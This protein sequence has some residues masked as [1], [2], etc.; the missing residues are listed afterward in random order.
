M[1]INLKS[2]CINCSR[3]YLRQ[4]IEFRQFRI[5]TSLLQDD[6]QSELQELNLDTEYNNISNQFLNPAIGGHAALVLQPY[7]KWGPMKK[8][9]TTPA[10]QLSEA[11]ALIQTLP[12]WSVVES[13]TISLLTLK[14]N[15]LLGKGNLQMLAEK[16]RQNSRITALFVSVNLLRPVQVMELRDLL[17]VPVYDRYSIVIQIFREHAKTH[18]AKLQVALAELP[19]IWKKLSWTAEDSDGR[20]HLTEN[21]RM[22]LHARENKLK[23]SLKKLKEHR[24]LMRK[25]RTMHN[26][27]TIAIVGY[28]NCGKTCLIK[29]LTGDESLVPQDKL[30]ATLDTTSH[31]GLLPCRL[32]VLYM[33]TIGFIQDL[34]EGLMEPFVA[35]FEDAIIAVSKYSII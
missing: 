11:E 4:K 7:V 12:R 13:M 29:A 15:K 33:D 17:G 32:K 16:V 20:V 28:T 30:F 5:Y 6:S 19:Y 9:N 26:I 25:H 21:R 34:P 24:K 18:E 10:L 23:T 22:V 2:I 1:L 8:R 14:K 31:E 35:T 3:I 27:P